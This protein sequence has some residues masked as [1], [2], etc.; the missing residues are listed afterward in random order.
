MSRTPGRTRRLTRTASLFSSILFGLV[1]IVVIVA[2]PILFGRA[3]GGAADWRNLSDIGQAYGGAA[4]VLSAI[5]VG[6]VVLSLLIQARQARLDRIYA[7]RQ[8][9]F[10]ILTFAIERNDPRFLSIYYDESD[11]DASLKL[12]ANLQ[13]AH[14]AMYWDLRS[15]DEPTLRKNAARMFRNTVVRDWWAGVGQWSSQDTRQRRQ[16]QRIMDEECRASQAEPTRPRAVALNPDAPAEIATGVER[17][18]TSSGFS[19]SPGR[20]I[21]AAI[22]GASIAAL[23]R[24]GRRRPTAGDLAHRRLRSR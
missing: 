9:H 19:D 13:V 11:V 24:P 12:F 14:W 5:A 1:I 2:S 23:V 22:A 10:E 15:M 17:A 18:R 6:G 20:Y 8:R 21:A 4:A 3:V 7:L 16:F